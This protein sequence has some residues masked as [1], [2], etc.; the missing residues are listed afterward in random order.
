MQ[1]YLGI[2]LYKNWLESRTK[3]FS[4]VLIIAVIIFFTINR[5]EK[6]ISDYSANYPAK[7][8]VFTQYVWV[9]LYKGYLLTM[10]IFSC[11]IFGL[12]GLMH[13]KQNGSA[14]FTLALPL[15]RKLLF[16][17]KIIVA[18]IEMVLL[19]FVP[20]VLIP[21]LATIY[22]FTYPLKDALLFSFLM[23]TGGVLFMI[24]GVFLSLFISKELVVPTVGVG[25][26]VTLFFVSKFPFFKPFNIF[27]YMTGAGYLSNDNFL[28]QNGINW[29]G[30]V[31][32]LVLGSSF[33]FII[34]KILLR[35][36]F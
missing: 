19:A 27:N 1:N 12:G 11:F 17:S 3:F 36:D 15:H 21:G 16:R 5:S 18:I 32:C 6:F 26:M 34:E 24:L 20:V 28:F 13:E 30:T 10:F 14:L 4:S 8:L 31:A 25:I 35:K 7:H 22:H 23:S 33:Y 2:L 29:V 9:L